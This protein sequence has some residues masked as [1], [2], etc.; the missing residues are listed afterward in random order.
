MNRLFKDLICSQIILIRPVD[1]LMTRGDYPVFIKEEALLR[2]SL[3]FR[4]HPTRGL[5][6]PSGESNH[7]IP[8]TCSAQSKH[9]VPR[10]VLSGVPAEGGGLPRRS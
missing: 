6:E 8:G 9:K 5:E 2:G 4:H 10:Q 7:P 3:P 1:L